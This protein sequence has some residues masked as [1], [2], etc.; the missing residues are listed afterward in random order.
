MLIPI[1]HHNQQSFFQSE[2]TAS[3]TDSAKNGSAQPPIGERDSEDSF[4]WPSS[5]APVVECAQCSCSAESIP[6][7]V[8]PHTLYP[9]RDADEKL[10]FPKAFQLQYCPA[11]ALITSHHAAEL[12]SRLT[13]AGFHCRRREDF[14]WYHF[15]PRSVGFAPTASKAKGAFTVAPSMLCHDQA[16]PSISSYS[17]SPLR[18]RRKNTPF[19]FQSKKYWWMELALPNSFFGKAFHWHPVRN[20]KIMPSKTFRDPMGLR[21]PPGRR[22]YFRFLGRFLFG[23]SGSTRSQSSSDTVHDLIAL[24]THDIINASINAIIY[25]RI[26]S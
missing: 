18:Q 14:S 13:T 4:S 20:T 1:G 11:S 22:R 2:P 15:F 7:P 17:A 19:R 24:M 9:R 6:G 16:I 21:P 23:I 12:R 3:G 25:L 5:P 10:L 26:S 8:L